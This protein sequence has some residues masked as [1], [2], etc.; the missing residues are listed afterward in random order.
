[1][2][3]DAIFLKLKE[4]L[5]SEFKIDAALISY[6]K[7]WEDDLDLDSLDAIDLL[8]SL[9]DFFSKEPDP[10]LFKDAVTIKDIVDLLS[11][12]WKKA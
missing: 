4:H 2:D 3:T 5:I 8:Y 12:I 11:L 6:E 7:R 1:L 10:S 9:K